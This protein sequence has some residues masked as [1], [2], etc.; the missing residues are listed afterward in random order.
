MNLIIKYR[1][2]AVVL[3]LASLAGCSAPKENVRPI[4][5]MGDNSHLQ[6]LQYSLDG[7]Y[8]TLTSDG[9]AKIRFSNGVSRT[10]M[11]AEGTFLLRTTIENKS[12]SGEPD[13]TALLRLSF[14]LERIV[15]VLA[16][17][18]A[19][20]RQNGSDETRQLASKWLDTGAISVRRM[21]AGSESAFTCG[22]SSRQIEELRIVLA[23][24]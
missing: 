4:Q 5:T 20:E 13:V 9:G 14:A 12:G 22:L 6:T 16:A 21:D 10:I 1:I 2:V 17:E 24:K 7:A 11:D 3:L 18:I 23:P 15:P 19:Y 8:L